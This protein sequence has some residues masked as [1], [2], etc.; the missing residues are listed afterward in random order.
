MTPLQSFDIDLSDINKPT[1]FVG[2]RDVTNQIKCLALTIDVDNRV[3]MLTLDQ[4]A[5]GR[6]QGLGEVIVTEQAPDD[7]LA[8]M[9]AAADWAARCILSLD[10]NE[11]EQAALE[12]QDLGDG[13]ITAEVLKAVAVR[14]R[15]FGGVDAGD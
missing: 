6:I 7:L 8:T 10:P 1:I 15:R 14:V 12:G 3:P 5:H 13:S 2:G 11:V 9:K 4:R